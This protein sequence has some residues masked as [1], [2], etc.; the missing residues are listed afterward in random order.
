MT[1]TSTPSASRTTARTRPSPAARRFGYTV[2]ALVNAAMLHAINVWP[3]WDAL[4]FLTADTTLVLPAVNT[5]LAAG[6]AANLLY[7]AYD[8]RWFRSFG[9]LVTTGIGLVATLRIWAVF[10][11]DFVGA[12]LDWALVVRVLL[13]LGIVGSVIGMAVALVTLVRTVGGR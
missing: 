8:P 10:P 7:L 6:L 9:D 13:V 2:A 11:F 3:G 12:S 5:T 4:P 1:V